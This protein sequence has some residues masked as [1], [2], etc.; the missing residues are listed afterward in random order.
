MKKLLLIPFILFVFLVFL[1]ACNK[2]VKE[3]NVYE[4]ESYSEII[5]DSL[6]TYT[7]KKEIQQFKE[8]FS[9]AKKQSGIVDMADP[10]YKVEL[11]EE[12][13]FLWLDQDHGTIMNVKDTNTIYYLTDKSVENMKNIFR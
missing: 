6:V 3:V 7:N 13:F 1:N 12:S 8:A 9:S 10:H 5:E 11:G 4:M 2:E